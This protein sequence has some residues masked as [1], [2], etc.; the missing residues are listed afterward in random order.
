MKGTGIT[1]TTDI[2]TQRTSILYEEE[3]I[4]F[5]KMKMWSF[6]KK[7]IAVLLDREYELNSVNFWGNKFSMT[8]KINEQEIATIT[9]NIWNNKTQLYLLKEDKTF[10]FKQNFWS[11]GS[12]WWERKYDIFNLEEDFPED[13]KLLHNKVSNFLATKGKFNIGDT[14]N[15][16]LNVLI[17]AGIFIMNIRKQ[18][19]AG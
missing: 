1:W 4:G 8:D 19:A 7:A 2:W 10:I 9:M 3:E 5:L 13:E 12:W 14:E 6:S 15:I 16:N 11:I 17:L 18:A